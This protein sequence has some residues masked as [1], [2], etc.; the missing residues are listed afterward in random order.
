MARSLWSGSISFGLVNIPV[1]LQTA[2]RDKSIRFHQLH[3]KDNARVQ[4]KIFC[5]VEDREISRDEIARGYEISSG[6]YVLVEDQELE[7]VEPEKTR[8][9]DILDFV[10]L[11][12]IDPLYYDRPYYLLPDERAGKSYQLLV[13]AMEKANKVAIAKFVMHDKEYLAAIRPL[14]GVLCLEIMHYADEVV[15]PS[16]AAEGVARSK[17]SDKEVEMA[18]ALIDQLT[19]KFEPAKYKDDYRQKVEAMIQRKAEGQEIVTQPQAQEAQ[20]PGKVINLMEA[21]SASLARARGDEGQPAEALHEPAKNAK[22][23]GAKRGRRKSA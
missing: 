5:P 23:H 7:S 9:I 14:E 16:Q 1:K 11:A 10:D 22:A 6:Q 4:Y 19:G 21:L 12:E 8:R 18:L 13:E 20:R 3:Q 15:L 2:A 17:V